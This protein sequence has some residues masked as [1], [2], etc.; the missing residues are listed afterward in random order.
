MRKGKEREEERVK[1]K[2][3]EVEKENEDWKGKQIK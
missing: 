2:R 1:G 3:D